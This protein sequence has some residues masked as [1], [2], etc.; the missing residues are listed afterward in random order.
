MTM[1]SVFISETSLAKLSTA[2]VKL[3]TDV[4]ILRISSLIST[5]SSFV[6]KTFASFIISE[7]V[8]MDVYYRPSKT[9]G[10]RIVV[11]K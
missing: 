7:L 3:F 9:R 2:V 11:G 1:F 6:T 5:R 8:I 10:Q 4:L